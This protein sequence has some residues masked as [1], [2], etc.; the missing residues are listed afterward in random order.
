MIIKKGENKIAIGFFNANFYN[1]KGE[2]LQKKGN[3]RIKRYSINELYFYQIM[4]NYFKKYNIIHEKIIKINSKTRYYLDFFILEKNLAIE[5]DPFFHL[6][7]KKVQNRDILR[8]KTIKDKFEIV[9]IR[10]N[11][12]EL[13][14]NNF[15]ENLKLTIDLFPENKNILDYYF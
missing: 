3:K 11:E 6:T 7:Y 9:T 15:L 2:K 5:I 12:K 14:N 8:D 1:L 4:K 10:I 13:R